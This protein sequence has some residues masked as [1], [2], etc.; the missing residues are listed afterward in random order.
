MLVAPFLVSALSADSSDMGK[1]V[2]EI[3]LGGGSFDMFLH[4]LK[5]KVNITA[6]ELDSVVFETAKKWF[7]VIEEENHRVIVQDGL[8][9]LQESSRREKFDVIALD[10][11]DEAIKSPCPAKVFRNVEVIERL[12]N[13]LAPT[14]Q[15]SNFACSF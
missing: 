7:G 14:G 11:C 4:K 12:K 10:A 1:T 9:Y 2:L 6:V 15:S 13:A 5:P 8:E 3:G